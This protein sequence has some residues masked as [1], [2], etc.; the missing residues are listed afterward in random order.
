[1]SGDGLRGFLPTLAA[2][3]E[4]NDSNFDVARSG[5]SFMSGF[6]D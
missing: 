2:L 5:D 3:F 6:F 4:L 1:M